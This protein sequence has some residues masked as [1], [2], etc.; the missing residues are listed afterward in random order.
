MVFVR[1]W[2]LPIL[3]SGVFALLG[4]VLMGLPGVNMIVTLDGTPMPGGIPPEQVSTILAEGR[5]IGS[6]LDVYGV[7]LL[8]EPFYWVLG[9]VGVM[10]FIGYRLGSKFKISRMDHH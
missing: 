6:Y 7:R 5:K 3:S 9:T 1:S 4:L 8:G 10:A 2:V